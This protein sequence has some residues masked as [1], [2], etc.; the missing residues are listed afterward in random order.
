M[1]TLSFLKHGRC[2]KRLLLLRKAS[3]V[4]ET[5]CKVTLT[6]ARTLSVLRKNDALRQT[7]F[8]VLCYP[9]ILVS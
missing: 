1:A 8:S 5:S 2:G 3:V 7:T 4:F 6:N 9:T